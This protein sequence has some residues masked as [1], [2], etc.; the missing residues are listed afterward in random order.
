[1]STGNPTAW[2]WSFPGGSPATSTLQT[3]PPITYNTKGE[4]D[5]TLTSSNPGGPNTK[6]K[7]KYIRVGNVGIPET[8]PISVLLYPNPANDYLVIKSN[9]LIKEIV[10]LD[11]FG[12]PVLRTKP[13]SGDLILRLDNIP[14]GLYI[15]QLATGSGTAYKKVVVSKK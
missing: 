2:L 4:Y 8:E 1:M 6:T 10:L 14:S 13:D 12:E 15:M 5:V 9:R 11:Q 7:V 3:P